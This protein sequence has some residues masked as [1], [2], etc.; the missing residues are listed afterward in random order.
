MKTAEEFSI[1]FVP[2][3]V[4]DTVLGDNSPPG[5]CS[6]LQNL[7][8]DPGTPGCV[9]CRPASALLTDFST[10][11]GTPGTP[12]V[13]TVAYQVDN[14]IYGLVGIT[15]GTYAGKDYPFAYDTVGGAFITMSGI[16]T[17]N[18]P[19]SQATAGAWV[20][21]QMSLTGVDL[22]LTHIGFDG[23]SNFFGWFDITTPSAPT[24]NAGNTATHGLPTVPQAVQQFN[25]RTYF[26]CGNIAFYTDTLALTM[27]NSNQSFTLG[28]LTPITC[29]APLPVGTTSQGIIQ[30]ILTFKINQVFL[31][32]GDVTFSDLAVNLLSPSVGTAA[33]RSVV[34]TPEG[35]KF[36][37][38]DGI[39]KI[40]FFGFVSPPDPDLAVPFIYATIP[41]RVAAGY[42]FDIYRI[43][44][45]NNSLPGAPFQDYWYDIKRKGWNGPHTFQYDLAIPLGNNFVLAANILPAKLWN[46]FVVQGEEGGGS[47][48]IE[49]GAQLL[50]VYRT[51]PMTD[52]GNMYANSM[53]RATIEIASPAVGAAYG[54]TAEN[55]SG[56]R[57]WLLGRFAGGSGGYMGCIS[58]GGWRTGARR[59]PALHRCKYL[60]TRMRCLTGSAS[61]VAGS[62]L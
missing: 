1:R 35:V 30:G 7:I 41:S 11:P 55:E 31:I 18:V 12:G 47:T 38:L 52:A 29:A 21:P 26:F 60:G 59:Q 15:A 40:D 27:T 4:S 43:C 45:Q 10:L 54:F 24:W 23:V 17:S 19:I 16:T 5:A 9:I 32:T 25:N 28:D 42:N 20:P 8:Y 56:P 37:A 44:V 33:P 39:R 14:I 62:L 36:M 22:V 50:W 53:K 13:V 2:R 58:T 46:S 6:A 49:N 51:S 57:Y 61:K 34:P 48:F 3:G